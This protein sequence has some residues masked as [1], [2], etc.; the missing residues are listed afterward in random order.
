MTIVCVR[1]FY[2]L[3]CYLVMATTIAAAMPALARDNTLDVVNDL[4]MKECAGHLSKATP[5]RRNSRLN[6]A[7]NHV[8]NGLKIR[9]A[10]QRADYRA[11]QSAMLRLRGAQDA[12]TLK[13]LLLPRY[14]ESLVDPDLVEIGIARR[15]KDIVIVLAA[16]F[17]PPLLTDSEKVMR[18]VLL[19]VNQAR[20]KPQRCGSKLFSATTPVALDNTLRV[21]ALAHATDIAAR[22]SVSHHGSDGSTPGDR[23]TRAG[24]A[25][26]PVGE[27]VAAGQLTAKEVVAGWLASPGHCIN[28]MDPN[29]KQMSVAYVV[30]SKQALGIYWAQVFA[31]RR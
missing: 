1:V 14:C 17:A 7:A 19:Y 25:W 15:E 4:R 13:R 18:D 5:L 31:T 20:A 10:L 9:E 8:A 23:V 27:N 11:D 6:N 22:G 29:F 30:N 21:A 26:Q 24:Y 3:A 28:I 12:S 16:P 2:Y